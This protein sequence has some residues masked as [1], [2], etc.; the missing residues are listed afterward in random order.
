MSRLS[1]R[2]WFFIGFLICAGLIGI[3]LYLQY[4]VHLEPC[5]LCMLQRV[6]F[7]TVG[8]IFLLGA[9]HGPK[10]TGTRVYAFLGLLATAIFILTMIQRVFTGPLNPRWAAMPDLTTGERIALAPAIALIFALGLYPQLIL[11]VINTTVIQMVD[12]LNF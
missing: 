6:A 8:V 1:S 7:I 9:L 10:Q 2:A 5:P 12:H 11:G 4:F 3:A